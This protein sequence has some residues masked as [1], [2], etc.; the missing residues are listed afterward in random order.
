M[1]YFN[2][3]KY[4]FYFLRI[5]YYL[6]I[7]EN[8]K[9]YLK[10]FNNNNNNI[11]KIYIPNM[12][13]K[14]IIDINPNK[15]QYINSVPL[16][17]NKSNKFVLDFDWDKTNQDLRKEI[18]H[19]TYVTCN[20]LFVEGKKLEECSNYLHFKLQIQKNKVYKN[21]KNDEDI[22]KFLKKKVELFKSIKKY[23]IKRNFQFNIQCMIDKNFNLVKINSGNHRMSISRILKIQKIPIEI[24]VIHSKLLLSNSNKESN[25]KKIN[26]LIKEIEKK[27]N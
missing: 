21:C 12:A 23:G 3:K 19:P 16:K 17:F 1:K 20:E 26:M 10:I 8:I 15:I 5:N 22:I 14:N 4:I 27:Y 11:D 13:I 2:L 9:N 18:K 25:L 24:K 6:F 7:F